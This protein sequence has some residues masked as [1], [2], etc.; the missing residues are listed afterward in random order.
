VLNRERL[1]HRLDIGSR[2]RKGDLQDGLPLLEP[3]LV[4]ALEPFQVQ[5][6]AAYLDRLVARDREQV[7]VVALLLELRRQLP[8]PGLCVAEALSEGAPLPPGCS[9]ARRFSS[10]S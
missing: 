6:P 3:V 8:E 2:Y 4:D 7:Q 10:R 5:P 1:Q 9:R